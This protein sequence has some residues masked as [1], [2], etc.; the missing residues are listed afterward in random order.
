M[1][2]AATN[3]ERVC[4]LPAQVVRVTTLCREHVEIELTHKGF[5]ESH[6]GQFLELHCAADDPVSACVMDWPVD[7]FPRLHGLCFADRSAYLN[8]PFSIADRWTGVDG[9]PHFTVI[10]R[11]IGPGTAFLER[12]RPGDS[13]GVTGPLGVGFQIPEND[14][15]LFLVGGG[16]GIP[17]LLYLARQLHELRHQCVT[18]GFGVRERDLFPL[19]LTST[20]D[21]GGLA[22]RCCAL[23][24]GADF[25]SAIATDDGSLGVRGMVTTLVERW[26]E[27]LAGRTNGALVLACG[28]QRML[29]ALADQT[30]RLGLGAQL[31]IERNMG[32][33]LGTC[34][35]CVVRVREPAAAQGWRWALSCSEGPVFERDRLIDYNP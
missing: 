32:C 35:S 4:A 29:M 33:G 34:L 25:P 20:P 19:R 27:T 8:R 11:T 15:P 12:L 31:C 26:S 28:P 10:S 5:P 7:G 9:A 23:P 2:P 21:S 18:M 30:R 1:L 13:L 16:V 22:T 3:P 24:G 6:P 17:P 14:V